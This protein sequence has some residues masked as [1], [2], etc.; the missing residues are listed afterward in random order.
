MKD[1]DE[2][3]SFD[4]LYSKYKEL[5]DYYLDLSADAQYHSYEV[6]NRE[7]SFMFASI[8]TNDCISRG[9]SILD[10]GVRYLGGTNETYGNIN[11]SDALYAI[12]TLVFDQ[13]KYTLKELNEAAHHNFKG[14][15]KIR[16]ELW[17][18]GKYGNDIEEA[19]ELA[20]D[21]YEFVAKGNRDRGLKKGMDYFLIVISNNQTNT[22]WGRKT[23]AS[24]DG[25]YSGQFMNPANNPQGGADKNGPTALLNSL[26]RF[27]AKYHG[28]SVQNIKFTPNMFNKNRK[29]IKSLFDTY[30]KKGGCH[31]MVTVVDRGVLK[32]AQ[33]HPEKYPDLVVRVSGFSAIFVNLE[34]DVQDEVMSRVLYDA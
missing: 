27:D 22:E 8:L 26:S 12:K 4:E 16:E 31:L 24:L 13:K 15:E 29:I 7:V 25:R 1:P 30:F 17:N 10:G 9:K 2:Y 5:L 23:S 33:D 11:S 18:C 28:G 32:D 14:Y 3:R 20:N 19:D 34:R 21:L 6:M